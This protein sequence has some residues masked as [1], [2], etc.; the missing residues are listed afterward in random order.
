MTDTPDLVHLLLGVPS[1]SASENS[2]VWSLG[3]V[4]KGAAVNQRLYMSKNFIANLVC[5]HS[6]RLW[7]QVPENLGFC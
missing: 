7:N 3:S 1:C 4:K 6:I 2:K 5:F